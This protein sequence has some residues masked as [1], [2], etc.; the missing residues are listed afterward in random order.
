MEYYL[1][2]STVLTD[3]SAQ[4]IASNPSKEESCE[5]NDKHEWIPV[6]KWQTYEALFILRRTLEQ[7]GTTD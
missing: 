1:Q 5:E 2:V 6:M 7:G 3:D 4:S